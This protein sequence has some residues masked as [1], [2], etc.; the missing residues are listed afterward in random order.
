MQAGVAETCSKLVE[1]RVGSFP[2]ECAELA[3]C[4]G[5]YLWLISISFRRIADAPLSCRGHIGHKC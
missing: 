1:A 4:H 5:V 2:L 3:I